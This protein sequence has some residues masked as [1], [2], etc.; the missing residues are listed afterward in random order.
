[1]KRLVSSLTICATLLMVLPSH[2]ASAGPDPI[3]QIICAPSDQMQTR[4]ERRFNATRVWSGLRSPD[5]FMEL[6]EEPDG[7]W[8]LTIVYASGQTCIVAMGE[9]ISSLARS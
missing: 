3:A 7:D 5:E 2:R 8:T 6:W 4:L 9:H 1:M